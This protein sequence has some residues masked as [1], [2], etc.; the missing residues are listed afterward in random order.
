MAE[1]ICPNCG[2]NHKE[3]TDGLWHCFGCDY[4]WDERAAGA[5]IIK[6]AFRVPRPEEIR[7]ATHGDYDLMSFRIQE[8]KTAMRKGN[9]WEQMSAGQ[10][11]AL[12]LIATKIGRIVCG[13]PNHADSWLDISGYAMLVFNRLETKKG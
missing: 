3:R 7:G 13:D 6:N 5:A 4:R 9:S 10:R 8:I 12:E 1:I 2:N 11:E